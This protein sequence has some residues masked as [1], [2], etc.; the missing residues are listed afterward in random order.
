MIA[1]A[2]AAGV[3]RELVGG[4][5]ATLARLAAAGFPVPDGFVL[6]PA[7]LAADATLD[8]VVRAAAGRL[9]EG[10]FAVRSSALAE[11][12]PGAS[13][14]G[15]YESLLDVPR[16]GLADA[17]RW[18]RAAADA[19]RVAA[20]R[21][22]IG[23]PG[24][25]GFPGGTGPGMA[26]LVQ[27][28]VPADAAGVA[29]TANPVTGDRGEV[30]VTAVRGP[31]ERLVSGRAVGDEWSVV[32]GRVACRRDTEHAVDAGTVREVAALAV[33]IAGLAGRP[34]DVEWAVAAGRVTVLQARPMTALPDP[35]DWTPPRPGWWL[36]NFR[37]GELL[38]EPVTPLFVDWLLPALDAG[39][40]AA[41][42]AE[43]GVAMCPRWLVQHGWYYTAPRPRPVDGGRSAHRL[44]GRLPA[45]VL[46]LVRPD[47]VPR[48]LARRTAEWRDEL[49]P[50]YRARVAAG[51]AAVE[52]AGPADLI[53]TV[54][55]VAAVAGEY[56]WST[57]VLAG[58]QWKIEAALGR[59]LR[60]HAPGVDPRLLVAGLPG[61][62]PE[63][64]AGD[65]AS[66]DWYW[67]PAGSAGPV[68][69]D[70]GRYRALVARRHA[71]E[72]A[73][74]TAVAGRPWLRRRYRR[75]LATAQHYA[76]VREQQT[77]QAALAWPLLRRCVVRLG[78]RIAG[79]DDP[80]DV[81]FLTR[82]EL[83]GA[84]G[85]GSGGGIVPLLERVAARRYAWQRQRRL[86][87]PLELG[88]PPAPVA[89][90]LG[91]LL[92]DNR[93]GAVP[94]DAIVVGQA[95]SPGRATG[96]VRILTDPAALDT[97]RPGEVLVA[98]AATPAFTPGF[99][100]AA[101][102]VTDGGTVAAHASLIAREYGI[103]AVVATGDATARLRTGLVV[104]VDGT[105][106]VV[107]PAAPPADEAD[108]TPGSAAGQ[109]L[110]E[111]GRPQ[112]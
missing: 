50:R 75:L 4:K 89:K 10:P 108:G 91:W 87:A 67:P 18:C 34:Q 107:R 2:E 59:F 23:H 66:A 65:I 79:L 41:T 53:R 74:G 39:I 61:A 42:R 30:V 82:D 22:G 70:D 110:I 9:G 90:L 93:S 101:A 99:A 51:A 83:V 106:G 36:R 49:L 78:E 58:S 88:R 56:L 44:V 33:R 68:R 24:G 13:Y 104:T 5:A 38:P 95:A 8:E 81:F 46:L 17:V 11:D 105:A 97:L 55:E 84:L 40:A 12:L 21:D 96:A 20:Y 27:R 47:L 98:R 19:A 76:V 43:T 25:T 31:G 102:V 1:L 69:P 80:A 63:P 52:D 16:E 71:A 28:M 26:V 3:D 86:A 15:M 7:A 77:R 100:L 6:T 60:R 92:R 62:E 94:P 14:A 85:G 37:L 48:E 54:D 73:A 64:A 112:L 35:V 103:P 109:G 29:L 32:G 45:L 57:W 72:L 111:P